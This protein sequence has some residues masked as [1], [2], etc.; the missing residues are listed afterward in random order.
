[1]PTGI[2]ERSEKN[3]SFFGKGKPAHNKG[4]ESPRK[5]KR[6]ESVKNGLSIECK[7]HGVHDQWRYHSQNNVQCKICAS[8]WQKKRK[9]ERPLD[10]I[11]KDARTHAKKSGRDFEIDIN[12]LKNI[13]EIQN[14]CCCLTG[15]K[16]DHENLPSL[17][18]INSSLGYIRENIQLVLI[19][20]NKMKSNLCQNEFIALCSK[21]AQNYRIKIPRKG[22]K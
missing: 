15:I 17:D 20:V 13:M 22:K 14:E 18:R 5:I 19:K 11:F 1:M 4:K 12:M 7:I 6:I 16:F 9:R 3:C 10:Q 21:I 2:Y 8:E